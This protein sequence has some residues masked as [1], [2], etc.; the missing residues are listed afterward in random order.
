MPGKFSNFFK[1]FCIREF[2]NIKV[3]ICGSI[4]RSVTRAKSSCTLKRETRNVDFFSSKTNK[5]SLCEN[6]LRTKEIIYEI[7]IVKIIDVTQFRK[8]SGVGKNRDHQIIICG[9]KSRH[10]RCSE[11]LLSFTIFLF[12]PFLLFPHRAMHMGPMP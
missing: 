8:S 10:G 7:L 6:K 11:C 1:T 4:L 12:R 9:F 3:K 2:I 5:N